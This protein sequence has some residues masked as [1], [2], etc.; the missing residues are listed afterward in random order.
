MVSPEPK[1]RHYVWCLRNPW[2]LCMVSSNPHENYVWCPRNPVP[3][4]PESM[5]IMYGV[6]VIGV[7]GITAASL[8]TNEQTLSL[9]L[10]GGAR[11]VRTNEQTS[12]SGLCSFVRIVRRAWDGASSTRLF[13]RIV[14]R[15]R[16]LIELLVLCSDP[17]VLVSAT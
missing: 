3:G 13:V 15:G 4:I 12:A 14:R 17:L 11:S 1:G 8:R 6:P 7:P 16:G 9:G 5:G 2:E 10:L